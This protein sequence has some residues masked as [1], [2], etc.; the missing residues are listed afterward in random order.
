MI[1]ESMSGRQ[2]HSLGGR[3][4]SLVVEVILSVTTDSTQT[5]RKQLV[6]TVLV[7]VH[8]CYLGNSPHGTACLVYFNPSRQLFSRVL[9][10][11]HRD[12]FERVNRFDRVIVH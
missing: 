6:H 7:H 12:G 5:E 9:S 3:E 1:K 10:D 11:C 8:S 2:K 4:A